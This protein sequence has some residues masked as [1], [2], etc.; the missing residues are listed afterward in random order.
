MQA[1]LN[2][3]TESRHG[4]R[5]PAGTDANTWHW[6]RYMDSGEPYCCGQPLTAKWLGDNWDINGRHRLT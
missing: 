6:I 4:M 1:D 2:P 3:S 5:P